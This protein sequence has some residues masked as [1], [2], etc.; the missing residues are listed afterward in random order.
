MVLFKSTCPKSP[1][2]ILIFSCKKSRIIYA[3]SS[4]IALNSERDEAVAHPAEFTLSINLANKSDP[5]YLPNFLS[6]NFLR[7]SSNDEK[8][9]DGRRD[10]LLATISA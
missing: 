2:L 4:A 5:L 6:I 8:S 1:S 3:Q 7:L 10:I 9:S